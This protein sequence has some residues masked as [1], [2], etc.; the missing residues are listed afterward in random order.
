M[1]RILQALVFLCFALALSAPRLARADVAPPGQPPGSNPEPGTEVTQVRMVA[2]TVLLDVL[3]STPQGSFG[4]AKVTA[5]FTMRNLGTASESMGVRFPLGSNNGF[6]EVPEIRNV[7][8]KVDGLPVVM[9]RILQADPL[10]STDPVPWAEFDVTF[11]PNQE[12]D[13]Q[14]TYLLEG[15][16]EYPFVAFGYI[17]HTG[18]GWKDSIGS[19][20]L[21]VRLPYEATIQNVI[22]EDQIGWSQ[23]TP[24]GLI[25]GQEVRWH[26][27]DL[28]PDLSHDF[29]LS[30]VMPSAWQKVLK[31]RAAVQANPNDGEAWG[32]LGKLYKEILLYRRGYRL[33]AGGQQLYPMSV[34]AY[35]TCLS[36]LPNDAQ[37]HAGFADLLAVHSYY[38]FLGSN[39][40]E[41][42]KVRAMQEIDRALTLAPNDPTVRGIA[43]KIHALFN[44]VIL[45]SDRSPS[46]YIFF[47]LTATPEVPTA[48][49]V[50]LE[51]TASPS[52][53]ETH[54]PTLTTVPATEAKPTSMPDTA[55][56]PLCG[57]A[58]LVPLALFLWR[59]PGKRPTR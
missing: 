7:S 44:D 43:E 21:I 1:K 28:E 25:Q 6:G 51:P 24:G 38:E 59:M 58:F 48:T 29:Q 41:H 34:S 49:L 9:R 47:W 45:Q 57:P 42:D 35:E 27:D 39:K 8:I 13:I 12:V 26:F 4:Q 37:W 3:A 46:G 20:D 30:L 19:A 17:F 16:G 56:N 18:A 5:D 14:V 40:P 2:E 23:T 54:L 22:F 31:E 55:S 53:T 33:D 50:P 36:L 32:R 15:T 11:P 52:A 10:W